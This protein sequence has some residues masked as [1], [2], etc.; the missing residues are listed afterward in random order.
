MTR[1]STPARLDNAQDCGGVVRE[2]AQTLGADRCFLYIRDPRQRLG[3]IAA[4]WRS[5]AAVPDL[6]EET[7]HLMEPEPEALFTDDPMFKAALAGQPMVVIND[8]F[9]SGGLLNVEFEKSYAHHALL[10]INLFAGG[11]LWG[12]LQPAMTS[13][14][15]MW[16]AD[17]LA[18]ASEA[19]TMLSP[20]LEARLKASP[21]KEAPLRLVG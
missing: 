2:F 15:R 21:W 20:L 5:A 14:P 1:P 6:P 13:A 17:D 19:R 10:H 12:V 8:V 4:L 9:N 3:Q 18:V 16:S 11:A 7:Y